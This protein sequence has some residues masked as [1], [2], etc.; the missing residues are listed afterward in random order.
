M[1]DVLSI[2]HNSTR[3]AIDERIKTDI[4]LKANK[5]HASSLMKRAISHWDT[6]R[7]EAHEV[8]L[9]AIEQWQSMLKVIPLY[10]YALHEIGVAYNWLGDN[11]KAVEYGRAA[12][13]QMPTNHFYYASLADVYNKD[14]QHELAVSAGK[15]AVACNPDDARS[16]AM[17]GNAHW[18]R[19]NLVEAEQSLQKAVQLAP[20]NQRYMED[21]N[22]L[23]EQLN[24]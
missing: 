13:L 6:N 23:R 11:E 4:D 10:A 9:Q 5:D 16:R 21:L 8:F 20:G 24:T 7:E 3:T 2:V 19:G 14:R 18:F 15:S 1:Q 12:T 17:L 22:K